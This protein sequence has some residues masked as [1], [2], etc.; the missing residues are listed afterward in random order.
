MS[1][2][3]EIVNCPGVYGSIL[4]MTSSITLDASSIIKDS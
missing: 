4:N 1:Q 3:L 2:V